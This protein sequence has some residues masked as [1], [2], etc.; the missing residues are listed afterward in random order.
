MLLAAIVAALAACVAPLLL[1]GQPNSEQMATYVWLAV[2]GTLGSWA[3]LVPAKF[4]E[5]KVEDQVPL[6]ISLLLLGTLVGVA[7]WFLGDALML[8]MP[9]WREPIDV[10]S[11]IIT[12]EMLGWP[13]NSSS[14]NPPIAVYVAYFA[15]LFLVPR[16]WRQAEF[17][18]GARTEF[19]ERDQLVS[20][21]PGC[22][23]FFGGFR[24]RSA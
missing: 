9:G 15:F 5:G 19:V 7:A 3:V 11:G 16:W 2:V 14:A 20:A 12:H 24:N 22:C 6:R 1:R 18:R 21:G 13:R 8:K 17:T 23:T 10:G 4:A